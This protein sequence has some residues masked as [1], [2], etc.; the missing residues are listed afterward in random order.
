[1]TQRANEDPHFIGNICLTR[2][3]S[4]YMD[5]SVYI[6]IDTG[7]IQIHIGNKII[8]PIFLEEN[9]TGKLYLI[10]LVNLRNPIFTP[11]LKIFEKLYYK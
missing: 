10:L 7:T 6:I 1:M 8:D 11:L 2:Q 9:L 4:F 5:L 3:V